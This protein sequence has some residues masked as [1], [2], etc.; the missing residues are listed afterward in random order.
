MAR[1]ASRIS[2]PELN[3]NR[4]YGIQI[5]RLRR[6]GGPA[7]KAAMMKALWVFL[8]SHISFATGCLLHRICPLRQL[9]H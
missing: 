6:I 1:Q 7:D 2:V 8:M 4:T 5:E 9:F 3:R